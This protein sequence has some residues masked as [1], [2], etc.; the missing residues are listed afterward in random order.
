MKHAREMYNYVE[1]QNPNNQTCKIIRA[2][3]G[4]G[5][6]FLKKIEFN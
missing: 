1:L 3:I 2:A 5:D 4:N 6:D